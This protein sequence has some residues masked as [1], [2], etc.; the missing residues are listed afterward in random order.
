MPLACIYHP[1]DGMRVVT[2]EEREK[3]VA[4]GQWFRHPKDILKKEVK[5]EKPIRQYTRQRR[6]NAEY[7]TKEI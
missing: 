6:S 4:S 7:P 2:L 3:L 5:N 1:T